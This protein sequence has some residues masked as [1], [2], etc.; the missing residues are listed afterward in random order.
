[1]K[2]KFKNS[3]NISI[4]LEDN[5]NHASNNNPIAQQRITK[6][7]LSIN[8]HVCEICNKQFNKKF[9]FHRHIRMHFL[10]E[11]MNHQHDPLNEKSFKCEFLS[12]I[13]SDLTRTGFY[14]R[15]Q[16]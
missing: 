9:N 15:R 10:N 6:K 13:I 5:N 12:R 2:N 4:N 14:K 8:K 7:P 11:I 3:S 16:L 1:M